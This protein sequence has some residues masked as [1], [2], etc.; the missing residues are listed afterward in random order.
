MA[1]N[2]AEDDIKQLRRLGY[3]NEDHVVLKHNHKT[4]TLK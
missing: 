3:L 2:P 4:S 1:S